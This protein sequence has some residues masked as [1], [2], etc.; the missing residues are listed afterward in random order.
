MILL[1]DIKRKI[2]GTCPAAGHIDVTMVLTFPEYCICYNEVPV[3]DISH[4]V[5]TNTL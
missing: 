1:T 3:S 2:L 4:H 5:H